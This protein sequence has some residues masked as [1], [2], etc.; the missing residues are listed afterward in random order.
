MKRISS[1]QKS[2]VFDRSTFVE[3]TRVNF[4][5]PELLMEIK[6]PMDRQDR[7]FAPS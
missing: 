1:I 3:E 7:N 5:I 4:R 6:R 2:L